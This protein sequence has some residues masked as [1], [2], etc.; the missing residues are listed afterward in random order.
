[1][2]TTVAWALAKVGILVHNSVHR[3]EANLKIPFRIS[4]LEHDWETRFPLQILQP[5]FSGVG[6]S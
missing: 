5:G 2:R 4:M 1:M 6:E 3:F